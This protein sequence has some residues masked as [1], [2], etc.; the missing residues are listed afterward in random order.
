MT[1]AGLGIEH[2]RGIGDIDIAIA[3][4][5]AESQVGMAKMRA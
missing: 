5:R 2:E 3:L 4:D 1:G